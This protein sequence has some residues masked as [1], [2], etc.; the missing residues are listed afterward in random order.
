MEKPTSRVV[1]YECEQK[2]CKNHE[3]SVHLDEFEEEIPNPFEINRLPDAI[4]KSCPLC[5]FSLKC[6]HH[7]IEP[8]SE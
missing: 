1:W 4:G 7:N 2:G 5:G 3:D 8:S 6:K